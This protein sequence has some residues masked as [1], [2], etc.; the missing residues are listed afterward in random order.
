[1][2]CKNCGHKIEKGFVFC[3]N[4]G[5]RV[6]PLVNDQSEDD[7]EENK[8]HASEDV[9]KCPNCGHHVSKS[10]TFCDA[11]GAKISGNESATI[12]GTPKAKEAYTKEGRI[13]K[14]PNCG[15]VL[16]YDA[17]VC[18]SCGKEIRDKEASSLLQSFFETYMEIKS[19]EVDRKIDLI[20][21]SPVPNSREAIIEFMEF[22]SANFDVDYYI[23]NR[24]KA[25]VDGAWLSKI[26]L[27]YEKGKSM[28][29]DPRDLKRIEDIYLRA[30]RRINNRTRIW[31]IAIVIA[32]ALIIT[33]FCLTLCYENNL[34][35]G[36]IGACFLFLGILLMVLGLKRK[37]TAKEAAEENRN[38]RK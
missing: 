24:K 11:C 31:L 30:H 36:G 29:N 20:R 2:F 18:P 26:D 9:S 21:T 4:C 27:C 23:T 28:F 15:E 38:K 13:F 7:D 8:Y 35:L 19:D 32:A 6:S 22:A 10:A 1:M 37:K 16:P 33:G 25:T 3:L 17:I 14:C 5:E 34:V 12:V